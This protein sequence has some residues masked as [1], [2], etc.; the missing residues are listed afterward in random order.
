MT[1]VKG[2][3]YRSV[4][5]TTSGQCFTGLYFQEI[6]KDQ[7]GYI[8]LKTGPKPLKEV[9]ETR[10]IVTFTKHGSCDDVDGLNKT[11]VTKFKVTKQLKEKILLQ[12]QSSKRTLA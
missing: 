4:Y 12:R 6:E 8:T 1:L 9:K 2:G 7:D 10:Q 11:V 5:C 3:K